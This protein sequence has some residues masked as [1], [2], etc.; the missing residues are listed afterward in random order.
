MPHVTGGNLNLGMAGCSKI[1]VFL[2]FQRR[3][4]LNRSPQKKEHQVAEQ[5]QQENKHAC[6]CDNRPKKR[7]AK[8]GGI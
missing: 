1:F 4:D 6:I 7:V 5:E 2:S 3:Q 8:N